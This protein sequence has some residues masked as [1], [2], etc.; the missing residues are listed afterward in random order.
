[1]KSTESEIGQLHDRKC[2]RPVHICDM[3]NDEQRKAQIALAYLSEK[4][5]GD[6]KGRVVYNGKPTREYLGREDSSSPTVSLESILL[7]GMV[8]AH[9]DRDVMTTDIPNAFIQAPMPLR[10]EKVIMKITG[11]LVDILINMHPDTYGEYVVFEKGR[12]VLYVEILMALYGICL[13]Y[14]S[15]AAD[16]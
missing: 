8:D 11:R 9:E 10:D 7:T 5:N 14:T 12:K 16:E 3:T 15:D 6:V 1:M 13:L 4:R 2:F